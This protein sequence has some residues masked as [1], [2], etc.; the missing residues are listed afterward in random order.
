[1]QLTDPRVLQYP[2]PLYPAGPGRGVE[3]QMS[4]TAAAAGNGMNA[5]MPMPNVDRY[6]TV[7]EAKEHIFSRIEVLERRQEETHRHMLELRQAFR[8]IE[9]F[10]MQHFA[11]ERETTER[12]RSAWPAQQQQ[13]TQHAYGGRDAEPPL[14]A[15][16]AAGKSY[17]AYPATAPAAPSYPYYM[18]QQQHPTHAHGYPPPPVSDVG[19][20]R[21]RMS[22]GAGYLP[23]HHQPAGSS[24]PY[25]YH[26]A[27]GAPMMSRS[28][29]SENPYAR[30]ATSPLPA[31][32]AFSRS[33]AAGAVSTTASSSPSS[34]SHL[35]A[36]LGA[37]TRS[38]TSP[39][40][41]TVRSISICATT[42]TREH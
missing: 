19:L 8:G 38:P 26:L 20:E 5:P 37:L 14:T 4:G 35:N 32:S 31:A 9:R 27:G 30:H 3:G 39:R 7:R 33:P 29:S 36:A 41:P 22:A 10:I 28:T 40:T 24:Y 23:H 42:S 11:R 6:L 17:P 16:A 15:A 34:L 12:A 21:E 18:Q 2:P 1:V 13:H 25:S